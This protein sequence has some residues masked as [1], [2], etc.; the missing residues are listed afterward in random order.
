[1][2]F[3]V[4]FLIVGCASDNDGHS[5]TGN[6][7]GGGM[8]EVMTPSDPCA[9]INFEETSAVAHSSGLSQ[10]GYTDRMLTYRPSMRSEDRSIPVHIWYPT[11][12]TDGTTSFYQT[13]FERDTVFTDARPNILGMPRS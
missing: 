10:I 1:M 11:D 12:E 3:M 8:A 2:V 7:S 9:P 4:T 5:S 6:A 13:V